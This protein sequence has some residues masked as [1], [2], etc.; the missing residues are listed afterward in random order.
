M[1]ARTVAIV[2]LRQSGA[3]ANAMLAVN[4]SSLLLEADSELSASWKTVLK[5]RIRLGLM[6]PDG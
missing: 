4:L 6:P 1:S 2:S 3:N 5:L